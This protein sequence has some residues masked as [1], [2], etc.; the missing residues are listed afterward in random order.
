VRFSAKCW[1]GAS[2]GGE[3]G[4]VNLIGWFGY[5]FLSGLV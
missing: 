4:P 2:E 1:A 5:S 3:A